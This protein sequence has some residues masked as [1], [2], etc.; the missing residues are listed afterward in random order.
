MG[1]FAVVE[2]VFVLPTE[3]RVAEPY[4]KTDQADDPNNSEEYE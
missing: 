4:A 3:G 2:S 1:L